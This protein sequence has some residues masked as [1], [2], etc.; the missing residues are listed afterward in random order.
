MHDQVGIAA[1]RR[2]KMRVAAQIQSEVPV[3]FCGIFRLRLRAQD[4]LVDQLLGIAAFHASENAVEQF[5]FQNAAFRERNIER[6]EEFAQT[7]EPSPSRARRGRDRSAGTRARSSVSAAATFAR[8]MN[9]SINR[10][11]SSR[12]GVITRST[13]AIAFQ[14]DL[15]LRQI[16]VER[17]AFGA[18]PSPSFRRRHRGERAPVRPASRYLR[19]CAHRWPTASAGRIALRPNASG[20]GE[21]YASACARPR[22]SSCAR[23]GQGRSSRGRSEHRSFE[24]RSGSIGTTRSGK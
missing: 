13:R 24:M 21:M 5:R 16:E 7:P 20:C 6:G 2:S 11:A 19:R 12:S 14:K 23:Q 10:C 9:S 4:N 15:A 17:L 8:I 18:R 1:D 3:V 22:R